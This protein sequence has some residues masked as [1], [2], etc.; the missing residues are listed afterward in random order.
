MHT[1]GFLHVKSSM[2]YDQKRHLNVGYLV[3]RDRLAFLSLA[4]PSVYH[5]NIFVLRIFFCGLLIDTTTASINKP[6]LLTEFLLQMQEIFMVFHVFFCVSHFMSLL[7][8]CLN[9]D[10]LK[11]ILFFDSRG[12]RMRTLTD[13]WNSYIA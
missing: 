4:S 12:K 13:V 1:F 6:H 5:P 7:L 3:Q 11:R 2:S 9:Y 8:H 10:T